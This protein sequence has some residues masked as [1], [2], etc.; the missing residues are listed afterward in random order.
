MAALDDVE[1]VGAFGAQPVEEIEGTVGIAELGEQTGATEECD[2]A[3]LGVVR[4]GLRVELGGRGKAVSEVEARGEE[5]TRDRV[6]GVSELRQQRDRGI[7]V[8]A[9]E[10]RAQLGKVVW[11]Q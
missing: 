7:D 9:R 8:A 1:I 3:V 4:G 11:H 6:A 10:D 2:V 5:E